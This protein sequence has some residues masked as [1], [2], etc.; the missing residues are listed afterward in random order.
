MQNNLLFKAE[1]IG[2]MYGLH[3]A[4]ADIEMEI[5][6]GE[7]IGLIG[8]NGAGKSTLLKIIAGVEEATSGTMTISGKPYNGGSP[9]IANNMGIGMVFQEQSLIKNLTVAQ[10]IFLGSEK[11]YTK[12]GF[13]QW[14]KMEAD[15]KKALEDI[16]VTNIS[17]K[18]EIIN[19]SFASRQMVEIAKICHIVSKAENPS[20]IL[21]DEPTSV[22]NEQEIEQLFTQ[23]KKLTEMGNSVI[24]VSH[25]LNEVM[26]ISDRI[27]VFKDGKNSG[28]LPAKEATE[29]ILYEKMVG[30]TTTGEY[31]KVNKQTV[32]DKEQ[33]LLRVENLSQFGIFKDISFDL[34]KGEV[35]GLCG[36][37]G[38]GKEALC[39]V[40]SGDEVA[41]SGDIYIKGQK[42]SIKNPS[43]ALKQGILAI[44]K[45]RRVEGMVGTLSIGENIILSSLDKV[46]VNGIMPQ[47]KQKEL[48]QK[49]IKRLDVKCGGD[50]D[51]MIRL[52]GGN[53]QKV[54]FARAINSDADVLILNHPTRGVDIG[55][56]EDIYELIREITDKGSAVILLGDTLDECIG[57]SSKIIALKDGE[58][59]G[60]FDCAADNK[61]EQLDIVKCML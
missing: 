24:F 53:A 28:L 30:R 45:E 14:A 2:K 18:E 31:F 54:V 10:N 1:G 49:W 33:E 6:A 50:K 19:L 34:C 43:Q 16:G 25:R 21:L 22:L 13:I 29:A 55:S 32:P 48:A 9:L 60:T 3:A 40:I 36:V 37:E 27:Y 59:S 58:V 51:L 4:L 41:T 44:P 5:Y 39:A 7:I 23:M 15:A 57:I 47:H 56:K 11:N 20:M 17:P 38:S 8:E 61:P 52:S 35:L 46:A 12:F 26:T 42:T